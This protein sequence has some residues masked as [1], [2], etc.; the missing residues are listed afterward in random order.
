MI[1]TIKLRYRLLPYIYSTAG[2]CVQNKYTTYYNDNF[3]QRKNQSRS[4]HRE[5]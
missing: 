4:Q 5:P 1:K 3:P 2:D